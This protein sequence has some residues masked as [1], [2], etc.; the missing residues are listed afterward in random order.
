M[1]SASQR[2]VLLIAYRF[3]PYSNPGSNRAAG[4]WQHLG[5]CG[6][7]VT[8]VTTPHPD[9]D[10]DP[11]IIEASDPG[12]LPW[13]PRQPIRDI[14]KKIDITT[15]ENQK[16]GCIIQPRGLRQW[17]NEIFNYPDRTKNWCK[18]AFDAARDLDKTKPFDIVLSTFGPASTHLLARR[19]KKHGL[20]QYWVGDFRDLWTQN[21]YRE[22]EYTILRNWLERRLELHTMADADLLTTVSNPMAEQMAK[23][24]HGA[25]IAVITNGFEPARNLEQTTELFEHFT[26]LYAGHLYSGRRDPSPLF[27]ALQQLKDENVEGA[28]QLQMLFRVTDPTW[29][30]MLVD[31]Y[32]GLREQVRIESWVNRELLLRE[33]RAA[34]VL[35]Q[36]NWDHPDDVG[37]FPSK[38]FEYLNAKRPILALGGPKG[39]VSD[40]LEATNAGYHLQCVDDLKVI[41]TSWLKEYEQ[42]GNISYDPREEVIQNYSWPVLAKKYAALLDALIDTGNR[43][44]LNNTI[45]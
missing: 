18:P 34:T 10:P 37:T 7:E 4:L 11:S 8:V 44:T 43:R 33:Q 41:L 24:H 39:V 20:A 21:H 2:T 12:V 14:D 40:L 45:L 28:N 35:L 42:T 29:L 36:L 25:K 1:M 19:I 31:S 38:I 26:I 17:A 32:D 27:E 13:I 16:T 23:L 15:N 6:W 5:S 30:R 9:R 3:P 22:G